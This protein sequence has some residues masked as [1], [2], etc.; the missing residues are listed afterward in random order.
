MKRFFRWFGIAL[1]AIGTAAFVWI[2]LASWMQ[3]KPFLSPIPQENP[4]QIIYPTGTR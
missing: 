3:P 1:I 4:L 2:V